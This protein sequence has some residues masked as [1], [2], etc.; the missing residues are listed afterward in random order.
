MTFM[1]LNSVVNILSSAYWSSQQLSIFIYL[2]IY[3]AA[4]GLHGGMW[5]LLLRCMDSLLRR[6]GSSLVVAREIQSVWAQ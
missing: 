3:L 2:F 1:F 5:D 6:A 4:L